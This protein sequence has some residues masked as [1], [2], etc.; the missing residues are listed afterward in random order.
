[1][2]E[3]LFT[4]LFKYRPIV[5]E[6]GRLGFEAAYPWII[7]AVALAVLSATAALYLAQRSRIGA[8]RVAI[9][10]AHRSLAVVLLAAALLRPVLRI[11]AAVPGES[12][13]AVLLDDS[14]S[15]Q[16]ADEG[17][18]TR[19]A[20]AVASFTAPESELLAALQQR[21][22]LRYY[23]F[24][25]VAS[26][27][28]PTQPLTFDG[29]S[30]DLGAALDHVRRD[31]AGVPLAGAVV[32]TDGADNAVAEDGAVRN[33]ADRAGAGRSGAAEKPTAAGAAADPAAADLADAL[34]QLTSRGIPIYTVGLGQERFARDVELSRLSGPKR[35]LAG[36][37]FAVDVLIEQRGFDGQTARL[38]V[39]EGGAIA[40]TRE[41][42]FERGQVG[43]TVRV[44]LEAAEAGPRSY[45]FA[46]DPMPDEHVSENNA[47][48]LLLAVEDRREKILYFEGEPRW[49][50]SFLRQALAE[51]DQ[52]HL[53]VLQRTAKNK[54]LRLG[55]DDPLELAAAF[56]STREELF[57]YRGL[58]LGTVEARYFTRNQ[59][60]IL[61]EFVSQRGGGLLFLGGRHSFAE[62]GYAGTPL[63]NVLPVVLETPV[64]SD[65]RLQEISV[66]PTASGQAHAA[67]R[68]GESAAASQARWQKLPPLSTRNPLFRIKP[69]ASWLLRGKAI[70][71]PEGDDLV[72]LASQRYG[73][74]RAMAFPVQ[75]SWLWQMHADIPP[76]DMTH[77]RLWRQLLR[78]LISSV[79]GQVEVD[80]S[81]N[82]VTPGEAVTLRA[83]VR[84]AAYLGLNG[85]RVL[86]T[87]TDPTGHQEVL[88]LEWTVDEDGEYRASFVP[89]LLGPYEVSVTAE[90][91]GATVGSDQTRLV[92]ADLPTEHFGAEMN[93]PLLRRVAEETG[94]R[95]YTAATVDNL[96]EDAR[97]TASGKTVIESYEL[98]DMP[99]VFLLLLSALGSEWLLRR[100]WGL[101]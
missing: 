10:T 72:V 1:M 39:E 50:V 8:R 91:G 85:A 20:R 17:D 74:G 83:E 100:R 5:F 12:F 25:S 40:A 70:D 45:R 43:S 36:S 60:Q 95:F 24:S 51:D 27:F 42:T 47:R 55:V 48:T 38:T 29:H 92:A 15:M 75:D 89:Q 93:A 7:A 37:A 22:T 66:L 32:V 82:Q 16:L 61:E 3:S 84:D 101:A 44:N 57:A 6:N 11:S 98:W 81:R 68:L 28:D 73:R 2:P 58:V 14:R 34:L 62:G 46:V 41:V 77:E 59:L 54:Y 53:V 56:P 21:F 35:V 64:A 19:G 26:H 78:W 76:D 96:A 87:L 86:A 13:L 33:R 79:P 80:L 99:I 52:L 90:L 71:S 67:L 88:P 97:F 9:L 23:R 65:R 4:V 69:G 18:A 94:G 63:E 31:L 49:E 30:T